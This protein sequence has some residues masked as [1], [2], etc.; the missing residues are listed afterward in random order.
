MKTFKSMVFGILLLLGIWQI[1]SMFVGTGYIIPAPIKVFYILANVITDSKILIAAWHTAWKVVLA[2]ILVLCVGISTGLCLGLVKPLYEFFR[3]VILI[4]QAVPVI[5]WLSLVIFAWGIG[6]RGPVFIAF[7]SLIPI[8]LLTTVSGVR[9]LDKNLLEMA[10][11]YKISRKK[12]LKDIYIGSLVP[13]I[14]AIIDVTL[15]QAWKVILVAEYLCGKT[16]LGVE[17]LSARY[18]VNVAKVWALTLFAVFLGLIAER[19]VKK[20]LERVTKRWLPT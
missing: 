3:P 20:S 9:S 17:I 13:F 15:G 2:L 10:R 7:L 5:S 6:W 4:I 18:E 12:I 1:A 14:A 11:V 8:A 19:I 16:G